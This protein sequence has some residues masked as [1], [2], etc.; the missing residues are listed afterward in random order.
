VVAAVE[1]DATDAESNAVVSVGEHIRVVVRVRPLNKAEKA[2]GDEACVRASASGKEVQIK[3][4][5]LE[6]QVYRCNQCFKRETSQ[7]SFFVDSGI[8]DLLDSAIG[9]YRACAFAFGQTGAGKTY[10]MVGQSNTI[11]QGSEDDGL[12]GRSLEYLYSKLA[13]K[14]ITATLRLS[15]LEIYHEHVYDLFADE[16]ERSSLP[17]REHSTDGFFLEG[18]K[19]VTCSSYPIACAELSR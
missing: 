16:R 15:S 18:C 12:L 2:K 13:A 1:M 8:T 7:R 11:S 14:G 10:T 3:V 19:L 9:G 5:P 6:A 17:V 4:G